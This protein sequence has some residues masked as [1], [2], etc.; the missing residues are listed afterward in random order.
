MRHR[1]KGRK[2]GRIPSHQ[3]ALLRSLASAPDP[4]GARCRG[5]REQAQGQ[6][7]HRHH[8]PEGQG[9]PSAGRAGRDDRRFAPCRSSR[10]PP[11]WSPRASGTARSG[12]SGATGPVG[13]SGT[14]RSPRCWRPGGGRCN[15]WATSRPCRF[16][17]A[18][19]RP[20][21]PIGPAATPACCAW[22]SRAWA[23]PACAPFWSS[24]APT[25]A[26]A[27]RRRSPPSRAKPPAETPPR[28]RA[29]GR[30]HRRR[31][32]RGRV[33][34][35]EIRNEI[36]NP[37]AEFEDLRHLSVLNALGICFEIS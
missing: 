33:P 24:S 29:G 34:E 4:H 30:E 27:A 2:L 6:G 32:R 31:K 16:S 36:A 1:R 9:S 26:S 3:R 23:T 17:S 18:T 35:H 14:R 8:D 7:P 22:P 15:C 12:R 37:T 10:P 28:R 25:I 19:S 21:S 20:A 13:P 11:G 5:R